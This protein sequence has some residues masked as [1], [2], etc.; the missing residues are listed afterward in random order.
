M[1]FTTGFLFCLSL[2]GIAGI[3]QAVDLGTYKGCAATDAEITSR[4]LVVRRSVFICPLEVAEA[5]GQ[6]TRQELPARVRQAEH[7]DQLRELIFGERQQRHQHAEILAAQ[8]EAGVGQPRARKNAA[9]QAVE[10]VQSLHANEESFHSDY[11][12]SF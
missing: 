7:E 4:L 1:R 12:C 3:A 11:R 2:T 5:V 9:L 8:V 6:R 10:V